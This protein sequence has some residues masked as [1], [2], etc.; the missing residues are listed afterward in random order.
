MQI[1]LGHATP[2]AADS[3]GHGRSE[4]LCHDKAGS[5]SASQSD[6]DPL[7]SHQDDE[8]EN[9]DHD[10]L[11]GFALLPAVNAAQRVLSTPLTNT[12]SI[13]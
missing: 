10:V 11:R 4:R 2:P 8:P 5:P 13:E 1:I 3:N 12:V 9:N 6:N 7:C